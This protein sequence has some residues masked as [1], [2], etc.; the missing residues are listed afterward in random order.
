[1]IVLPCF[2]TKDTEEPSEGFQL[3]AHLGPHVAST[4]LALAVSASPFRRA[5]SASASP[6]A[7]DASASRIRLIRSGS[8]HGGPSWPSERTTS[9][10]PQ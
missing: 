7:S 10:G 4:S 3:A 9:S 8:N 1:M 2:T 6:R 5:L